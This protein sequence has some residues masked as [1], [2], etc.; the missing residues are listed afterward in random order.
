L[1]WSSWIS[2]ASEENQSVFFIFEDGI[3]CLLSKGE[4]LWLDLN[5]KDDEKE[6]G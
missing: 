4:I 6:N 2:W 3:H 5:E 1:S